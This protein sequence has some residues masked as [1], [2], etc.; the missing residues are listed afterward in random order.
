[1]QNMF[2]VFL[3]IILYFLYPVF[4]FLFRKLRERKYLKKLSK[5]GVRDIDNMD[6]LQFE[7]YLKAL[8]KEL[9]YKAIVTSG[10][11]DFGADLIMK[12]DKKKVVIQAKRYG[13]KNKV[14]LDAVQQVY[15]SKAYY[16][17]DEAWVFTNS[18]FTNSAQKLATACGVELYDRYRLVSFINQINPKT[19]PKDISNDVIAKDRPCTMC[20]GRLIQ[21]KSRTSENYFMGCSNYPN[22]KNTEKIAR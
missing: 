4:R 18:I 22:C 3:I 5:S 10:S 1:M 15:A 2:Y 13:H 7:V 14:S 17:A 20:G 12:K 9:G 21:R 11:Y 16:K 6:G 8:L 19:K